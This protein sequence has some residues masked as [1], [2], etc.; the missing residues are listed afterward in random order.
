MTIAAVLGFM[1]I[2][3]L[4]IGCLLMDDWAARAD[5]RR[6]QRYLATHIQPTLSEEPEYPLRITWTLAIFVT[7]LLAWSIL[8]LIVGSIRDRS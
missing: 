6:A 8:Q 2:L 7:L 5:A 3:A 1:I 4:V